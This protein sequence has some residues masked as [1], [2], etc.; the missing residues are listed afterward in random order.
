MEEE[1][2]GMFE[3]VSGYDFRNVCPA[4]HFGTAS[5]RYAGWIGQI[6]SPHWAQKVQKRR[7]QLGG[8]SY[9]ESVVP[10]E[11]VSEYFEHFSVLEIDFTF[12]R[13]LIESGETGINFRALEKYV[14]HAPA[15]ARFLVKAP[16]VFCSPSL[17]GRGA[18]P[19][20]LNRAEYDATFGIPLEQ[21]LGPQLR[22]VIF[23]QGYI[24]QR[25]SPSSERH[26]DE[27]E[28]FC[29]SARLGHTIH[30][31]VR[32]SHLLTPLFFDWLASTGHGYV[33]SHW[34]WLPSIK[35]QWL[36]AGGFSSADGQAVLRLLT[37]RKMS[38]AK[39]YDLAH[40]FDKT[41]PELSEAPGSKAMMEETVALA[42]K[43]IESGHQLNVIVNNR[44]WGSGPEL[45]VA[46][47]NRLLE[48]L[49]KRPK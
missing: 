27:L 19:D 41:I 26:V 29:S 46:V 7:K 35:N 44:A 43:A 14:E 49:R 40:P 4:V 38:Y 28:R 20:Y 6:Y 31:E 11:A 25:E 48:Y 42:A 2:A 18:N 5:D 3:A 12:Y 36:A 21:V 23:E 30:F 15:S 32:S 37:P 47:S 8:K 1:F 45:A 9:T 33:F 22:G 24:P 10:T 34:T 16:Q 17:P 13:P 39:A